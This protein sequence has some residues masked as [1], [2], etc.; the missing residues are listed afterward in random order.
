[1]DSPQL[2]RT[3]KL[4]ADAGLCSRRVAEEYIKNGEVTINGKTAELG[5]KVDPNKD[6]VRL[7]GRRVKSV[8][9]K[10]QLVIALNKPK[11]FICSN[12]DPHNE[13]TVFDLL[14]KDF[15]GERLFCAGRLDKDSEGLLILTNDGDL[16]NRL[17]HP[18]N[19]IT[20]RYH[21]SL[22]QAYPRSKLF[23]L[24]RGVTVE[25]EKL[26]VEKAVF[27]GDKN[28]EESTE[29]DVAMHHGK[30]REIRRLFQALHFDVKKLKRYQ[31][32]RYSIKGMPKGAGIALTSREISLLFKADTDL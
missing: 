22:K 3:Q 24:M 8:K 19:L 28:K 15:M 7:N 29:L 13:R 14:P 26:K 27:A 4:L 9:S 6:D 1:M 2:I 32:G 10:K 18:S 25:G 23:R 20:K 21:V 16:A 30:K 31:I 17:M 5:S 11:G 12:D